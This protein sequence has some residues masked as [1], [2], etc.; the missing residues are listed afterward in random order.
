MKRE[1]KG[2]AATKIQKRFRIRKA[3]ARLEWER[4][5]KIR[6]EELIAMAL[7]RNTERLVR[8]LF[9]EWNFKLEEKHSAILMQG[10]FRSHKSKKE[11][12][13]A[14]ENKRK[15]EL[16]IA[17]ALGRSDQRRK[18]NFLHRWEKFK[19]FAKNSN[20][21]VR[22]YRAYIAKTIV[23]RLKNRR[24]KRRKGLIVLFKEFREHM[25]QVGLHR[26]RDVV[27]S[28]KA[29][30]LITK[31]VRFHLRRLTIKRT[32]IIARSLTP[33]IVG[34]SSIIV[35]KRWT[36]GSSINKASK[37]KILSMRIFEL[38]RRG[39]RYAEIAIRMGVK[40]T[41][42][43]WTACNQMW[44]E[45]MAIWKW[46][47]GILQRSFR[48]ALARRELLRRREYQRLLDARLEIK[49]KQREDKAKL[50]VFR[51]FEKVMFDRIV[52][53]EE[54]RTIWGGLLAN[55]R[56]HR[57]LT[58]M[59]QEEDE[60]SIKDE[61][62]EKNSSDAVAALHRPKILVTTQQLPLSNLIYAPLKGRRQATTHALKKHYTESLKS[63]KLNDAE[64]KRYYTCRNAVEKVGIF[65]WDRKRNSSLT[66]NDK[67]YLFKAATVVSV[68]D[69]VQADVDE[70]SYI[71]STS[72][73]PDDVPNSVECSVRKLLITGS[74]SRTP[75]DTSRL[76]D[77]ALKPSSKI[78]SLSVSGIVFG[79]PGCRSLAL[80]FSRA[81]QRA[82]PDIPSDCDNNN[83]AIK[84][85]KIH[86]LQELT[87]DNTQ[88]PS[89][90]AFEVLRSLAENK[91]FFLR[92]LSLSNNNLGD[93]LYLAEAFTDFVKG[94][95][96]LESIE[97][98]NCNLGTLTD[99]GY[100]EDNV[101]GGIFSGITAVN[102]DIVDSYRDDYRVNQRRYAVKDL[103]LN[104]NPKIC[105]ETMVCI[106][107][108]MKRWGVCGRD[109]GFENVVKVENLELRGCGITSRGAAMLSLSLLELS[110]DGGMYGLAPMLEHIDLS[111]NF[112]TD[113]GARCLSRVADSTDCE[114][115]L[116]GNVVS[117][118]VLNNIASDARISSFGMKTTIFPNDIFLRPSSSLFGV[119]GTY[120][121]P[122]IEWKGSHFKPE[123]SGL[124]RTAMEIR[125]A[126][127]MS[128]EIS[129]AAWWQVQSPKKI[130]AHGIVALSKTFGSKSGVTPTKRKW[131]ASTSV[132]PVPMLT[133][134]ARLNDW[135]DLPPS[136]FRS[137]SR[138]GKRPIKLN[139]TA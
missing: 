137:L 136:Q 113:E 42:R 78:V 53:W 39:V 118:V 98:K 12:E 126:K 23:I 120:K 94:Q 61:Y 20:K 1:E 46:A 6:K 117:D 90:G 123:R 85:T 106:A 107:A 67:M 119:K 17:M 45:Q 25:L 112:I 21:I 8:S 131:N 96:N 31:F 30:L 99:G 48:C 114:I 10:L 104:S 38:R 111:D 129:K 71:L 36:A 60:K 13:R 11:V 69:C 5:E 76:L 82:V 79:T 139:L 62:V 89:W 130:A 41:R 124:G 109:I 127:A 2:R 33:I 52:C 24:E 121:L 43:I 37:R 91:E 59:I 68:R 86:Q 4:K 58:E 66:L 103:R 35:A 73:L 115:K 15:Q 40:R 70:I 50:A 132:E 16:I 57:D 14:R 64:S 77:E 63:V 22:C 44:L 138:G 51:A 133:N 3:K 34:L 95:H 32:K 81:S 72:F 9:R 101:V 125:E 108:E 93:S 116:D 122:E 105:D 102:E 100:V 110:V 56:G 47:Y 80:I 18:V 65:E 28:E 49:L 54:A 19:F 26:L 84:T 27:R 7:G 88:I 75:L 29:A 55:L 83:E 97:L 134:F 128:E 135:Y 87:L 92:R 74:P